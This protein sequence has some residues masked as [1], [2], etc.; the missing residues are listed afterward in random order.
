[1]GILLSFLLG[2]SAYAKDNNV[3]SKA[4]SR[5]QAEVTK[6]GN[7]SNT[8]ERDFSTTS[9]PGGYFSVNETENTNSVRAESDTSP[10]KSNSGNDSFQFTLNNK[11]TKDN[12]NDNKNIVGDK[13]RND[14]DNT[15]TKDSST[16]RILQRSKR[17]MICAS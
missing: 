1:M 17:R 6:K 8:A 15:H 2:V 12:S 5:N 3:S 11:G 9:M 16:S 7:A 4:T 14:R 13:N 10:Q